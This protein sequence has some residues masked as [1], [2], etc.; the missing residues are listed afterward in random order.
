MYVGTGNNSTAAGAV[1]FD[2]THKTVEEQE[3]S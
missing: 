2:Y 1:V 3:K